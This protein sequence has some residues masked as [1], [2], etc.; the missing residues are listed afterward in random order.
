M[1]LNQFVYINPALTSIY[2][3]DF[4]QNDPTTIKIVIQYPSDFNPESFQIKLS[5]NKDEFYVEIP[6]ETVPVI[7]GKLTEPVVDF[8]TEIDKTKL[9]YLIYLNKETETKWNYIIRD[10]SEES[11]KIDPQSS[12]RIFKEYSELALKDS[13]QRF[14]EDQITDFLQMSLMQSYM[15]AMLFAIEML[16]QEPDQE[17]EMLV[18][19]DIASRVYRNPIAVYKLGLYQIKHKNMV[20][21]FALLSR[22]AAAGIGIAYSLMGQMLSPYSGVDFPEKSAV[23][24]LRLFEKV[25]EVNEEPI[26]LYEAAKI[27]YNGAEEVPVDEEKANDYW[28]RAIA[29]QPNLPPLKKRNPPQQVT[30]TDK[31]IGV[32]AL[33]AAGAV[34]AYATYRLFKK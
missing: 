10:V 27:Y 14:N 15:P 13:E 24:A 33:V 28:K 5:E 31:V 22:A 7:Y 2:Q 26:A 20:E 11:K 16:E 25:I 18:L 23:E 29:K 1:N 34:L 9:E 8:S 21:G 4:A 6:Q 17:K 12:F 3:W 32:T 30:N 19:L